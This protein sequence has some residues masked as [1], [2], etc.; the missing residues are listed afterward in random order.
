[1]SGSR[2]NR[3]RF[4]RL[5]LAN[6]VDGNILKGVNK[7][8]KGNPPPIFPDPRFPP[9]PKGPAGRHALCLAAKHYLPFSWVQRSSPN[10]PQPGPSQHQPRTMFEIKIGGP[11]LRWPS[12]KTP[13][14][15][16]DGPVSETRPQNEASHIRP[17]RHCVEQRPV[18]PPCHLESIETALYRSSFTSLP[19]TRGMSSAR[20]ERR[21]GEGTG[22][23]LPGW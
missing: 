15:I 20:R 19:R 16:C 14:K 4:P 6:G 12:L 10:P 2:G 22:A 21:T 8:S 17:F 5:P 13:P 11:Q 1:M 3:S 7:T 9:S 18:A 23:C